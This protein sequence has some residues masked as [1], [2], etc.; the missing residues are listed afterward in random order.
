MQK[1][2]KMIQAIVEK[3]AKKTLWMHY[4]WASRWADA[5]DFEQAAY[6]AITRNGLWECEDGALVFVTAKSACIDYL[7]KNVRGFRQRG[8]DKNKVA[9]SFQSFPE[10]SDGG[11]C[12][13]YDEFVERDSLKTLLAKLPQ[14]QQYITKC[15][16]ENMTMA[17]IGQHLGV[18]KSR[19]SQ[20]RSEIISRLIEL[21][22]GKP[23]KRRQVR[24]PKKMTIPCQSEAVS[25]KGFCKVHRGKRV[26][27]KRRGLCWNCYQK[28]IRLGMLKCREA[29]YLPYLTRRLRRGE[30]D[31]LR[32]K[33]QH[34]A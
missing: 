16:I 20:V 15:L 5:K 32:R 17:D 3:Q 27:N 12:D 30:L 28:L 24:K 9:F 8:L 22:G 33:Y 1:I 4:R 18:T 2:P 14:V 26:F 11:C 29:E 13:R 10:Y 21:H 23:Q 6:E 7:R 25:F 31:V 34:T 19:I